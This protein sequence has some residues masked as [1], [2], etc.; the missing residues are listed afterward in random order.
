[1]PGR[2]FLLQK[3][4]HITLKHGTELLKEY[5][6]IKEVYMPDGKAPSKGEIF[7][8]PLLANTLEKIVKGGQ[9]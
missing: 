6:N 4:L 7:K 9:K 8:N 5:P 2:D 3:L 1:M